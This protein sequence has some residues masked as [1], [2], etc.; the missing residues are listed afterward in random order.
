[1]IPAV[2]AIPSNAPRHDLKRSGQ[3]MATGW[4]A[5]LESQRMRVEWGKDKGR[6]EKNGRFCW[7]RKTDSSQVFRE[8]AGKRCRNYMSL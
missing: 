7:Q 8:A 5:K 2:N 4:G 6:A 3:R 1:M